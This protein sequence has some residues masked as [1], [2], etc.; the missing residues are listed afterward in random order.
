M[1]MLPRC[2]G[3]ATHS[4]IKVQIPLRILKFHKGVNGTLEQI[5]SLTA[6]VDNAHEHEIPLSLSRL[7]IS[8]MHLVPLLTR[9]TR[10]F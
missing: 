3:K 1:C 5:F 7:W 6:I 2:F 10:I 4:A 9:T 8:E